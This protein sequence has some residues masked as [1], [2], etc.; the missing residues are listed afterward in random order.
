MGGFFISF[1]TYSRARNDLPVLPK[2]LAVAQN[3]GQHDDISKHA[4]KTEQFDESLE[5]ETLANFSLD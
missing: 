2:R 3:H 4:E 1:W 5:T